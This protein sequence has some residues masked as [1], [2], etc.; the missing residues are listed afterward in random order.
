MR[1]SKRAF[2]LC[3]VR[4]IEVRVP[5]CVV[6]VSN[7]ILCRVLRTPVECGAMCSP[8]LSSHF[9]S[10]SFSARILRVVTLRET[11]DDASARGLPQQRSPWS[12]GRSLAV[13]VGEGRSPTPRRK[14]RA[15]PTRVAQWG[16]PVDTSTSRSRL[17]RRFPR[18]GPL[19]RL[20]GRARADCPRKRNATPAMCSLGEP[21]GR[22]T[23]RWAW[24]GVPRAVLPNPSTRTAG[25]GRTDCAG[26]CPGCRHSHPDRMAR[27]H[28]RRAR[29]G[30]ALV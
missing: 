15:D 30:A 8:M 25:N 26:A 5:I 6:V 12:G 28:Q 17:N 27:E 11:V 3:S 9:I 14:R 29:R 21:R 20:H 23:W 18:R 2:A 7:P 16:A 1:L 22:A 13:A 4:R 19:Q 24:H 10:C